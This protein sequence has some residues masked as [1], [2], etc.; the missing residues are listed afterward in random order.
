M[1]RLRT[2]KKPF[3][4]L[5]L[6]FDNAISDQHMIASIARGA[7]NV[8]SAGVAAA[9]GASSFATAG[10]Y[11]A[12]KVAMGVGAVCELGVG[13]LFIFVDHSL[14]RLSNEFGAI[15][16]KLSQAK[17]ITLKEVRRFEGSSPLFGN[18]LPTK[19][20]VYVRSSDDQ[21]PTLLEVSKDL[22]YFLLQ[23]SEGKIHEEH[24][25]VEERK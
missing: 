15:E 2:Y 1:H 11:A 3:S 17:Q 24:R 25:V 14:D 6:K 4:E 23:N 8:L 22:Y 18:N 9:A 13:G 21:P 7:M 10:P 5:K 16:D 19:Y 20:Y 12:V